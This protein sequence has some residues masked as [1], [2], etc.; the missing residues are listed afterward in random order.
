M[1][2]DNTAMPLLPQTSPPPLLL[3]L[4][5][6]TAALLLLLG[7]CSSGGGS[8]PAPEPLRTTP[9][10]L[11]ATQPEADALAAKV[12]GSASTGLRVQRDLESLDDIG[13]LTRE[14]VP[15]VFDDEAAASGTRAEIDCGRNPFRLAPLLCSGSMR[16]EVNQREV[17]DTIVAGTFFDLQFDKF[18][19]FTPAFERLR[20]SGGLRIG[21]VTDFDTRTKRGTLTYESRGLSTN[22]GGAILDAS[23][24]ALTVSHGD[25][26][27]VVDS[28]T[29]RFLDL[30][31]TSASD[32]DGTLS[33]GAILSNFG[34]G[35]VDIRPAGWA[36]AG[37]APQ[38]G[39]AAT[40]IGAAG[41]S[42]TLTVEPGG[43][44]PTMCRVTIGR[45]GV[46]T[47]FVVELPLR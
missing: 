9:H 31:A 35:Y 45:A 47:A 38:A 15:R 29:E 37:G 33:G 21:Y 10:T 25:G 24:G 3:R 6:S 2:A 11:Q 18:Q 16:I 26:S 40:V 41:S 17:G 43:A 7:G 20:I 34:D 32:L 8:A 5:R 27:I 14:L 22:H 39:A 12:A 19:V 1:P 28:A 13:R 4:Q 23:E 42:A 30:Q 36:I 46:S 44:S